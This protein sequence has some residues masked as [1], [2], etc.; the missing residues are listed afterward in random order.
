MNQKVEIKEDDLQRLI[1]KVEALTDV[2]RMLV[3][4]QRMISYP[5]FVSNVNPP[6][7]YVVPTVFP[8]TTACGGS[9]IAAGSSSYVIK[10]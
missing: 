7:P 4:S 5:I 9:T 2:I 6:N 10:D 8:L 1:V 3:D